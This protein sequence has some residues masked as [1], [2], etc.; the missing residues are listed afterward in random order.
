MA[1]VPVAPTGRLA[2]LPSSLLPL[3]LSPHLSLT[4]PLPLNLRLP[5]SGALAVAQTL[6]PSALGGLSGRGG[7]GALRRGSGRR[8]FGGGRGRRLGRT[9]LGRGRGLLSMGGDPGSQNQTRENGCCTRENR[10]VHDD[11]LVVSIGRMARSALSDEQDACHLRRDGSRWWGG[12]VLQLVHDLQIVQSGVCEGLSSC[13][14]SA[15]ITSGRDFVGD[16][17][18][19]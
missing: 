2:H 14:V 16:A 11:L 17:F 1:S 13:K 9:R 18:F 7:G 19:R 15:W 6:L 8:L 5:L 4:G 10:G 3:P 12:F